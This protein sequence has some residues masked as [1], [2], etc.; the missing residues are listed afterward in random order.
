M[1]DGQLSRAECLVRGQSK[2]HLTGVLK[3]LG[4]REDSKGLS[5]VGAK[6]VDRDDDPFPRV[7]RMLV[8]I[9]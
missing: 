4:M 5:S 2:I 8:C 3:A 1:M 9:G 7:F 6:K